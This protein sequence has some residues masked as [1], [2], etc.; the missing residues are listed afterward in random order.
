MPVV[1]VTRTSPN[2]PKFSPALIARLEASQEPFAAPCGNLKHEV[3]ALVG[4]ETF[5]ATADGRE[6]KS[7]PSPENSPLPAPDAGARSPGADTLT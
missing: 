5:D 2:E 1:S 3:G 7:P 4:N 6:R